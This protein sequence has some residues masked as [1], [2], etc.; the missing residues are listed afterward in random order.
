MKNI[1]LLV[2]CLILVPF[3]ANATSLGLDFNNDSAEVRLDFVLSGDDYGTA[4]LGGRYLYNDD[5]QSE[6]LGVEMKFVGDPGAVPGLEVGAGFI[7]YIGTTDYNYDFNNVGIALLADYAPGSL[8]G[9]GFSGRLVYAPSIFSWQDSDGLFEYNLRVNYAITPKVKV[10]GG[11]QKIESEV[12]G[13]NA[14]VDIDDD[15][16]I[17]LQVKF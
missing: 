12:D 15:F 7:G 5:E 8:Q 3:S 14:D 17:G 1:L 4:I 2:L 16:R 10:Y 9:L 13:V 11:Y 6:T